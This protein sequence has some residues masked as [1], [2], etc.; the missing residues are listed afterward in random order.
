MTSDTV[1]ATPAPMA[2]SNPYAKS[3][4]ITEGMGTLKLIGISSLSEDMLPPANTFLNPY[5]QAI[6]DE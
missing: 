1:G 6:A 3:A 5:C 4:D 2:A